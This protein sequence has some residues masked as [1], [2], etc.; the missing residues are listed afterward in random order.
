[1]AF[2]AD[3]ETV[4]AASFELASMQWPKSWAAMSGKENV[5]RRMALLQSLARRVFADYKTSQLPV[6][7]VSL[8][9]SGGSFSMS[10]DAAKKR[11]SLASMATSVDAG[12]VVALRLKIHAQGDVKT[13]RSESLVSPRMPRC[14]ISTWSEVEVPE[15][16]SGRVVVDLPVF[17]VTH[18]CSQSEKLE[19]DVVSSDHDDLTHASLE[20][21]VGSRLGGV[22]I[23]GVSVDQDVAGFSEALEEE[24]KSPGSSGMK[25][26]AMAEQQR[27]VP[28]AQSEVRLSAKLLP[29]FRSWTLGDARAAVEGE[30]AL[31]KVVD[32]AA[33]SVGSVDGA[34][35]VTG[36]LD[37]LLSSREEEVAEFAPRWAGRDSYIPL[38]NSP[39][40]LWIKLIGFASLEDV[41][42]DDG[43]VGRS[44]RKKTRRFAQDQDASNEEGREILTSEQLAKAKTALLQI[45]ASASVHHA[46]EGETRD[47]IGKL[48]ERGVFTR[49]GFESVVESVG[50]S[51]SRSG[52]GIQSIRRDMLIAAALL[53]VGVPS[54]VV[55]RFVSEA[56]GAKPRSVGASLE[57]AALAVVAYL[58]VDDA[59][60]SESAAAAKS[61]VNSI[62][63]ADETQLSGYSFE[64]YFQIPVDVESISRQ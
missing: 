33:I 43:A 5:D 38:S 8:Q 23:S 56:A 59:S 24:S 21:A 62:F 1:M 7:S 57:A 54:N 61:L 20:I 37:V 12:D 45:A 6:A 11:S 63:N 14:I 34:T 13:M 4:Y 29:V 52:S 55:R 30:R 50:R 49:D 51:A 3:R 9:V 42:G 64:R 26:G 32:D 44:R 10:V 16:V 19:F 31:L 47:T 28:R 15:S 48:L 35:H 46:N 39:A 53:E 22:V 60:E 58:G 25:G 41:D 36:D 27:I 17:V 2:I 40:S 18:W